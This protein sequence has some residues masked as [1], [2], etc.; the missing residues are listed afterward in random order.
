MKNLIISIE[1]IV[2][3]LRLMPQNDITTQSLT[4]EDEPCTTWDAGQ[5]PAPYMV[6]GVGVM[7]EFHLT[8]P[9]SPAYRQ[10]G[11]SGEG[12]MGYFL[13][14]EERCERPTLSWR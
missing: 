7:L 11:A 12:L 14:E 3:I 4:G 2:E 13:T 10:A 5:S 1:S 9:L 6:Q 8:V